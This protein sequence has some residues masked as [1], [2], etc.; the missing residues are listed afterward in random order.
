MERFVQGLLAVVPRRCSPFRPP[1]DGVFGAVV[2]AKPIRNMAKLLL[3][4]PTL[5]VGT[6]VLDALRL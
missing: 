3:L 5:G 2:P 6:C 4:V 1:C